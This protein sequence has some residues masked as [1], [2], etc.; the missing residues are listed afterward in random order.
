MFKKIKKL[1]EV[2]Q[3]VDNLQSAVDK[4]AEQ[5]SVLV[6]RKPVRY[7]EIALTGDITDYEQ[8]RI[9]FEEKYYK[10]AI[11]KYAGI[12]DNLQ[13]CI[14]QYDKVLYF[15]KVSINFVEAISKLYEL[16]TLSSYIL[17]ILFKDSTVNSFGF[18]AVNNRIFYESS[19]DIPYIDRDKINLLDYEDDVDEDHY[20]IIN[21]LKDKIVIVTPH[22][23]F[24]IE[25]RY[26][27]T[28][29]RVLYSIYAEKYYLYHLAHKNESHHI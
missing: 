28:V 19:V 12:K 10:D 5:L 1:F 23:D 2:S 11:D 6:N 13:E 7:K 18:Y 21:M 8:L 4:M 22:E 9:L 26:R 27:K 25:N 14:I 16:F 17:N 29:I 20:I 15:N 24:E 3:K